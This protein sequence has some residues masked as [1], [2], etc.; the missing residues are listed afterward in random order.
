MLTTGAMTRLGYVYGNQMVNVHLKNEK[1]VERGI[2]ILMT[3]SGRS[4]AAA[5][6]ALHDS[7]NDVAIALIMLAR[8]VDAAEA[9][10]VNIAARGNVRR[11]IE[12]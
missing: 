8:N 5:E 11:A 6:H 12:S 2:N 3:A 7:G 10:R 4:R 1:L 9:R